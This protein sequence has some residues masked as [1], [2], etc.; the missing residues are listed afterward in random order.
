[1]L[2]RNGNPTRDGGNQI[3]EVDAKQGRTGIRAFTILVV[4]MGL[5]AIA[6]LAF[7]AWNYFSGPWPQFT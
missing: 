4:S 5:L 7:M 1:M 2:D 6:F 3:S